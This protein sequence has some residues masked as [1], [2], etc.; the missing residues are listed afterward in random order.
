MDNALPKRKHTR[1]QGYDYNTAGVYFITIC[2][3]DR[4]QVLSEIVKPTPTNISVGGD[5]LDAPQIQL[6]S[7]G[8]I[9]DKYIRQLHDFYKSIQVDRY[10]IMPDHVHILLTVL[11]DGASRTSPP[12]ECDIGASR[13]SPPTKQ[14]SAV[15]RFV[16]TLKRFCNKDYGYN[17]WQRHFYDHIIRD[18]DDYEEH[19]KYIHEN[20]ISWY[21][22]QERTEK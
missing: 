20:P 12:T 18:Q 21:Y 10:V 8:K 6:L 14:H 2:T 3:Q 16:S 17:I 15:S 7:Y 4:K 22:E 11:D 19:L 9:V 5:V 1:L 13:T